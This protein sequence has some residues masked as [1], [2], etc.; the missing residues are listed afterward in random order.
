[1]M[2]TLT[3]AAPLW[4]S[5]L[6]KHMMSTDLGTIFVSKKGKV[7]VVSGGA[8]HATWPLNEDYCREMLNLA[9]RRRSL[10]RCCSLLLPLTL[11]LTVNATTFLN[12]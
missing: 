7:P 6:H 12:C 10:K 11:R 2:V 3:L 9:L 5:T 8:T 1:M 4:I